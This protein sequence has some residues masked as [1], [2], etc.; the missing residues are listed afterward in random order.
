MRPKT[1]LNCLICLSSIRNGTVGIVWSVFGPCELQEGA[2]LDPPASG[3]NVNA[4]RPYLGYGAISVHDQGDNSNDNSLQ[5]AVSRRI[6]GGFSLT[7]NYTF[8]RALD[9][10]SGTPQDAF[11]GRPDYGLSAVHRAQV[12]NINYIYELQF[13]RKRQ[14]VFVRQAL[15]GWEISGVTFYQTGAPNTVSVPVDVARIGASSS[16]ASVSG[17]PNLPKGQRT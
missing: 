17:D 16:R 8:S 6:V 11:D 4:L 7:A 5:V 9:D 14:N 1:T 13:W 15:A 10:T 12:V 3:I 2:R